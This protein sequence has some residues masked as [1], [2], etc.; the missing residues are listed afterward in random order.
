MDDITFR[1]SSVVVL[2]FNAVSHAEHNAVSTPILPGSAVAARRPASTISVGPLTHFDLS[3]EIYVA[4]DYTQM[5]RQKAGRRWINQRCDARKNCMCEQGD[6]LVAMEKDF[7]GDP[8]RSRDSQATLSWCRRATPLAEYSPPAAPQMEG[9]VCHPVLRR[10]NSSTNNY[11]GDVPEFPVREIVAN[12][13]AHYIRSGFDH[14][15]FYVNEPELAYTGLPHTTW[16]SLPWGAERGAYEGGSSWVKQHCLYLNRVQRTKWVGFFDVDEFLVENRT[17]ASSPNLLRNIVARAL[18]DQHSFTF[19]VFML[20]D[21]AKGRRNPDEAELLL[22]FELPEASAYGPK[23]LGAKGHRKLIV[24]P[25]RVCYLNTHTATSDR[26]RILKKTDE[27]N[28]GSVDTN[29]EPHEFAIIHLRGIARL[30][31]QSEFSVISEFSL[32]RN[33]GA[34][35]TE[36]ARRKQKEQTGPWQ[37]VRWTDFRNA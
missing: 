25:A 30:G 8:P 23:I 16:F 26:C 34:W 2:L 13:T 24:D 11:K 32:H 1:R 29:F 28:R 3:A 17:Q 14:V 36:Y 7:E 5:K 15:Y 35:F 6:T 18:P 19:P 22:Q 37:L 20:D 9:A 21:L 33:D 10:G 4:L 27:N 12:W 31:S